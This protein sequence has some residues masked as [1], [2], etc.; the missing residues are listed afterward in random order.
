MLDLTLS[1]TLKYLDSVREGV[2]DA[3]ANL[4]VLQEIPR[5]D[6]SG[7]ITETVELLDDCVEV[8]NA[9]EERLPRIISPIEAARNRPS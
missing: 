7:L 9:W 4:F 2:R 1:E 8:L 6:G 3:K 5:E